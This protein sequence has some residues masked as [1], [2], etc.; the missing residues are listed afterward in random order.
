MASGEER[1][2]TV[3][4]VEKGDKVIVNCLVDG[5]QTKLF[6]NKVTNGS[7]SVKFFDR[8]F[9]MTA[10]VKNKGTFRKV[11]KKLPGE[12]FV[13]KCKWK[14]EKGMVVIE[15]MKAKDESW[16]VQLSQRGLEQQSDEEED[17]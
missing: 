6:G 7:V 1:I 3:T 9:D 2:A 8:G 10:T 16:A 15:L 14:A 12:V 11:V 13:D 5:L 4:A 17:D